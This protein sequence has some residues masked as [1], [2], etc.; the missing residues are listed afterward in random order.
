MHLAGENI[1]VDGQQRLHAREALLT[2]RTWRRGTGCGP[3][4]VSPCPSWRGEWLGQSKSV[5][6]TGA[7]AGRGEAAQPAACR[8]ARGADGRQSRPFRPLVGRQSS[9]VG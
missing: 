8:G 9:A 5:P 6:P 1:E 7:E 2:P 3:F 4:T